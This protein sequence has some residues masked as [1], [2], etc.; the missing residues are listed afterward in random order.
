MVKKKITITIDEELQ[1]KISK[2]AEKEKRSFSQQICKLAEDK[3]KDN[4]GRN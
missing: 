2:L 3:L 4:Q 1:E